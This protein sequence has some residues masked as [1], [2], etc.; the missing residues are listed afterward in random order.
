M[1]A[2]K[3]VSSAQPQPQPVV[4]SEPAKKPNPARFVGPSPATDS[5]APAKPKPAGNQWPPALKAFV[6]RTFA[7]CKDEKDRKFADGELRK[8]IAKVSSDN[9]LTV[10]RWELEHMD[11]P[12]SK[13]HEVESSTFGSTTSAESRSIANAAAESKKR[14]SR[15][16]VEPD[17]KPSY[18]MPFEGNAN[19]SPSNKKEKGKDKNKK[20]L[21]GHIVEDGNEIASR[22]KRANRFEKDRSEFEKRKSEHVAKVPKRKPVKVNT[23]AASSAAASLSITGALTDEEL[24]ALQVVGTCSRLEKEYFR[25]GY[26]Q[27]VH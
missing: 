14:K 11:M 13:A 3:N 9:R 25:W 5:A 24:E 18:Y 12:S 27:L 21:E 7:M 22:D 10:H 19:P 20:V 17:E 26:A 2:P 23:A 4:A 16:D 15:F 6:E 1:A 8:L